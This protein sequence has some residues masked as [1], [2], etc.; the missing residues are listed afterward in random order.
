MQAAP[1]ATTIVGSRSYIVLVL[2]LNRLTGKTRL[3][4]WEKLG[5]SREAAAQYSLGRSPRFDRNHAQR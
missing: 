4:S 1:P 3:I 2:D 5:F